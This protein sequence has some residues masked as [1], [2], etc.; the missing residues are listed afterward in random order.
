MWCPAKTQSRFK[1]FDFTDDSLYELNCGSCNVARSKCTCAAGDIERA[2]ISRKLALKEAQE[3]VTSSKRATRLER[4]LAA[5]S[6]K[7]VGRKRGR[8]PKT[9][10]QHRPPPPS[11]SSSSESSLV[12]SLCYTSSSGSTSS[13]QTPSDAS[14]LS[15]EDA[16]SWSDT[17]SSVH[18]ELID[19]EFSWPRYGSSGENIL[20]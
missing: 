18:S 17:H 5:A 20:C 7:I 19:D 9:S 11:E 10:P 2:E 4:Q 13:S 8:P 3:K 1:P 6:R 12:H 16:V 15:D 14:D